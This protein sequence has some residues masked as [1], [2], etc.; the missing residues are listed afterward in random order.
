MN[1]AFFLLFLNLF[2]LPCSAFGEET[3]PFFEEVLNTTHNMV[4]KGSFLPSSYQACA[5][6]HAAGEFRS[7]FGTGPSLPPELEPLFKSSII[8]ERGPA[9]AL[10]TSRKEKTV[11]ISRGTG[12]KEDPSDVCL[13]CHDGVIGNNIHGLGEPSGKML[14]HPVNIPYPRQSNGQFIPA[15][16]LP[17][18]FRYWSIPDYNE[19][20]ISLP[21]GPTSEYYLPETTSLLL[22]R[23]SFG[24]V[25]CGSCHNPHSSKNPAYLRGSPKTLCLICHNR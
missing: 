13:S 9:Q 5:M 10:W 8:T 6:C 21:T 1:R 11:F 7:Y 12:A 24:K 15:L 23:T 17:N 14:D 20:G 16:P 3:L 22:V 18:E 19:N 25:T 2:F 4:P